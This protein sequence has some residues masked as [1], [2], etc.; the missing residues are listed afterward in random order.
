MIA[1][2]SVPFTPF[3]SSMR[4]K[5][6]L[7]RGPATSTFL[8]ASITKTFTALGALI[9]RERCLLSLDDPVKKFLPNFTVIN[10]YEKHDISLR[11]LMGHLS[12][13]SRELCA[14]FTLHDLSEVDVL[15]S[16]AKMELVRPL[17][18]R[19]PSYSNLGF[20][21]LGHS[22]EKATSPSKSW[23]EFVTEEIL[24]PESSGVDVANVTLVIRRR[25]LTP[26]GWLQ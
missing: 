1:E 24:K 8:I 18:S 10:P 12:G 5:P 16:V 2:N 3:Q 4:T 6:C 14:Y 11:E 25:G 20:G 15:K 26:A 19:E 22:W 7:P 17:W 23:G 9:L 13:L 21:V